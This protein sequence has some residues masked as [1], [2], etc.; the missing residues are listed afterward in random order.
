MFEAIEII[1]KENI[2]TKQ[3]QLSDTVKER[4]YGNLADWI[5]GVGFTYWCQTFRTQ[6]EVPSEI[7]YCILSFV[8]E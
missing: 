6:F 3:E 7:P 2:N 4:P 1:E 8:N 5:K